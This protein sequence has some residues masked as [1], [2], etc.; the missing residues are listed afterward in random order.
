MNQALV[1]WVTTTL[2]LFVFGFFEIQDFADDRT[3]IEEKIADIQLQAG[4]L[5]RLDET[6]TVAIKTA[7][8][9]EHLKWEKKYHINAAQYVD[10]EKKVK[11]LLPKKYQE[12]SIDKSQE[13][14]KKLFK[15]EKK[16]FELLRKGQKEKAHAI[17]FSDSYDTNKELLEEGLSNL[18]L[19]TQ[20][21]VDEQKAVQ[22]KHLSKLI[23]LLASLITL[24]WLGTYLLLSRF[25]KRQEADEKQLI[26]SNEE[27]KKSKD[28]Y[29]DLYENAPDMFA[30][31]EA[32]TGLV[33]NCNQTF[34]DKL[35]YSKNEILGKDIHDFYQ[36]SCM[37]QVDQTIE[38][39]AAT[40]VVKDSALQLKKKDGTAI[41]VVLNASSIRDE[42]GK[43]VLCRSIWRDVSEIKKIES[44]FQTIF[45]NAV[46][47]IL[48]I[49]SE[50]KII[51]CNRI[52]CSSLGYS[53]D[54]LLQLTVSD[55]ETAF[56]SQE[57][58][59]VL[60]EILKGGFFFHES[61]HR[62]KNG[63]ELP[64]EINASSIDYLDKPHILAIS[65]DISRRKEAEQKVEITKK[66]LL[67]AQKLAVLGEL[68]AGV[69]H[70]VLNPVNIISVH[71]QVIKRKYKTEA[72]IQN[73]CERVDHEVK[74]I[75]KI[76]NAM[77]TFSRQ[78]PGTLLKGYL[79]D[80]IEKTINLVEAEYKLENI[81]IVR[82][83]C[84]EPAEIEYDPDKMRQ[85]Y[86]NLLQNSKY[87]MP[88]GGVITLA[89]K[90]L[91]IAGKIFHQFTFSDTGTGMSDKVQSKIFE[92]FFTTKPE[93]EGTGMGLSV[94]HGIIQEHRGTIEVESEIDKGT[95]FTIN[96]PV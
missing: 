9:A 79:V 94:I 45:E 46:D 1:F 25:I 66:Q 2:S 11:A 20:E 22:K 6:L 61:K 44:R 88:K 53:R 86:L 10:A 87:A 24:I 7:I 19:F 12:K 30:S 43:P 39:Y 52:A 31:V 90:E 40:G 77:L 93:G 83:W 75:S 72:P 26:E 82:D 58:N 37:A 18:A 96:L 76:L 68:S 51:D 4:I 16:A 48:V 80:D 17:I 70:E 42:S 41:D 57:L 38:S 85:V 29:T 73:F 3:L 36:P 92:P 21:Y 64:V 59:T 49:S 67:S 81:Q 47:A 14:S 23:T 65:R 28:Q 55:I 78:V 84:S 89:C 69:S 35:G 60:Q 27:T 54:E 74:R 71:S 56:N 13:A 95:T 91:K 32:K 34:A 63:T 15:L 33:R 5:G 62:C 50:G 8:N